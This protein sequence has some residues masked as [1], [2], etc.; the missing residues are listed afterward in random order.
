[1]SDEELKFCP[2]CE[3]DSEIEEVEIDEDM[4]CRGEH[5]IIR[6]VYYRCPKCGEEFEMYKKGD[7]DPYE[8]LYTR[9]EELTGINPRYIKS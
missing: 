6:R 8:E 3:E 5:F 9:Y 4:E 1:M 2:F 7:Y